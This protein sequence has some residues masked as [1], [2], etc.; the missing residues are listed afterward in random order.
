M[1]VGDIHDGGTDGSGMGGWIGGE[2]QESLCTKERTFG[3][4]VRMFCFDFRLV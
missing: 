3:W 2:K 4:N 1:A